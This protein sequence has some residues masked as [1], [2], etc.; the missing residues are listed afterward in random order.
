[1]SDLEKAW[2]N[3]K[4]LAK[5]VESEGPHGL[6]IVIAA[7]LASMPIDQQEKVTYLIKEIADAGRKAK[8]S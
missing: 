4:T 8:A 3:S 2:E 5:V 7:I 6:I 1:M